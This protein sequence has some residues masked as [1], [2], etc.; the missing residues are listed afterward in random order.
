MRKKKI[1]EIEMDSKLS[2][3][4]ISISII[5]VFLV[6]ARPVNAAVPSVN[7]PSSPV[8]IE[9]FYGGGGYFDMVLSNVSQGYD[10]TNK[11]YRGW[12]IDRR[13]EMPR[14]PA[15]HQVTLFS[16]YY[17]PPVFISQNW[18]MVNY[19]LN[20]K[21]GVSEDIQEAI[22]YFFNM[23]DGYTPPSA[24]AKAIV[25][26]ALANGSN[27]NPE[28]GQV[29]AVICYTTVPYVQITIIEYLLP[30]SPRLAGDVNNDGIV[31]IYDAIQ[32]AIAFQTKPGQTN[33]N[34]DVDLNADLVIDIFDAIIIATNFGKQV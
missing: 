13:Y 21:Q 3:L 12:C 1:E 16:S 28:A 8:T 4:I 25:N 10:V 2:V 29:V 27:F 30:K 6:P 19:I 15:T 33:W 18:S 9:V 17:P 26:D 14:S 24:T 32:L 31:D 5:L 34:P 23:V 22:W 11:A 7:L 20:H